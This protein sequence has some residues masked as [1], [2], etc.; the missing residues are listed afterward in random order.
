MSSGPTISI[1]TATLNSAS[2]LPRL[3]ASLR[4]QTDQAFE[5]AIVDGGSEDGTWEIIGSSR[6]VVT[7]A[8]REPDNGV[9]DALNK[10]I[11][12]TSADFYLVMGADDYL[13]PT[14]IENFKKIVLAT[15]ADVVVAAVIAGKIVRRGFRRNRAWLGHSAMVTSHSVGML[16]KKQLHEQFGYY[17]LRY[18]TLAD[19]YFIKRISKAADVN[20]VPADFIAGEFGI[21]G[22]SNRSLVRVLCESWQIQ[23][24][25]GEIPLIQYLL[26]QLRIF[27]NLPRIIGRFSNQK[28]R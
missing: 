27:K 22:I 2:D 6:D 7:H 12:I 13:C 4:Q 19:G 9:Y 28:K 26:F 23:V 24:D 11:R 8:I 1:V 21:R 16:I 15:D 20:I 10:G 17:S 5:H 18:P 3:L 25:T 14:A